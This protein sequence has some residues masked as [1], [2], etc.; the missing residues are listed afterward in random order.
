M[1]RTWSV[2]AKVDVTVQQEKDGY[3]SA[4][5]RYADGR[6]GG[7]CVRGRPEDAAVRLALKEAGWE[8]LKQEK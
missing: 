5:V 2:Q 3:F 7:V 6:N 8:P 1:T 4:S